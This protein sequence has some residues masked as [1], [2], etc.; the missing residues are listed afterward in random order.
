MRLKLCVTLLLLTLAA[1]CI[2]LIVVLVPLV[3]FPTFTEELVDYD[4]VPVT[5]VLEMKQVIVK[6]RALC[7]VWNSCRQG[8]KTKPKSCKRIWVNYFFS[9]HDM[10]KNDSQSLNERNWAQQHVPLKIN[11][12]ACGE[13]PEVDCK[14]F[15]ENLKTQRQFPC[16]YNRRNTH[17]VVVEYSWEDELYPMA[18][19]IGLPL[20][21]FIIFLVICAI[22][23]FWYCRGSPGFDPDNPTIDTERKYAFE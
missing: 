12:Q 16:H 1:T 19:A 23:G 21:L 22:L 7:K 8:C 10:D 4:P 13:E 5:C 3:V 18:F 6:D 2:L 9:R 14:L 17:E 15:F 20:G 11:H